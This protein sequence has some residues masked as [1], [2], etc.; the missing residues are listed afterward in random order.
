[1]KSSIF[2]WI[3]TIITVQLTFSQVTPLAK[4][5]DS[6][7]NSVVAIQIIDTSGKVL[8]R[9]SGVLIH[10]K[11]ILTAG[12]VNYNTGK[13][14]FIGLKTQGFIAT[15]YNAYNPDNRYPFDWSRDIESHPDT[16]DFQKG[17][18]DTTGKI[19]P[20]MFIDIGL[21]FLDHPIS[22]MPIAR[23]PEPFLLND[24]QSY[25]SLLGVGFGYD[26][27][28]DSTFTRSLIDGLR[29]KW[30]PH[31]ITL[32]ND[33]WL[34]AQCDTISNLPFIS[35]GDSGAPLFQQ[36]SIVVGIWSWRGDDAIKPCPYS[37]WAVRVDNPKVLTWIKDTIKSRLGIDL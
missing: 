6:T 27:A 21:I 35:I 25:S 5:K 17:L 4:T 18:S 28:S 32:F 8:V 36:D 11:I 14:N 1:M 7:H 3:L 16:A 22:N 10:P 2:F 15:S 37:S 12:H 19:K 13:R 33:L 26:K 29:R 9:A 24:L 31:K 34:S 20:T 30:T 23:L